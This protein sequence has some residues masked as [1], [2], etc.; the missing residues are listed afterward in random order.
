MIHGGTIFAK[1]CIIN[2]R[3]ILKYRSENTI[4]LTVDVMAKT[5]ET[6]GA[7]NPQWR[8]RLRAKSI[9]IK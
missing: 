9:E 2:V 5:L 1:S 8:S 3:Q 6:C 7:Q 4:H